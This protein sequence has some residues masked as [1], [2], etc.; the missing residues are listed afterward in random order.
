MKTFVIAL[1]ALSLACATANYEVVVAKNGNAFVSIFIT[2]IG[3]V[4][5]SLPEDAYPLVENA[6]FTEINNG[7][8]ISL[9][10]GQAAKIYYTT[11]K[12]ASKGA[13]GWVFGMPISGKSGMARIY[14]PK[15]TAIRYMIPQGGAQLEEN[16][17]TQILWQYENAST[18]AVGYSL[19]ES[20]QKKG[21][22]AEAQQTQGNTILFAAAG[23][24]IAVALAYFLFL[25]KHE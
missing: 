12:H 3:N 20:G 9:R 11:E 17:S 6:E 14:L 18:L 2:E 25:R 16:D 8:R 10:E 13:D 22:T 19:P 7:I 5:I 21:E 23:V 1:L 4:S 24:A 15:G